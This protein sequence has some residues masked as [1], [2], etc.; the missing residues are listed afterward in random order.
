MG[1][2]RR[3]MLSSIS[4][5]GILSL[6]GCIDSLNL[7]SNR[8]DFN[9][10]EQISVSI[11]DIAPNPESRY[12]LQ[13]TVDIKKQ[14]ADIDGPPVISVSVENIDGPKVILMGT[15]RA[16]FGGETDTENNIALLTRDE[17]NKN[18]MKNNQCWNLEKEIPRSG[19]QYETVLNDGEKSNIDL[20]VIGSSNMDGCIPL[21]KYRFETNY[22]VYLPDKSGNQ[23]VDEFTWGFILETTMVDK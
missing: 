19:T 18:Q 16:V 17:W 9:S 23:L 12:N 13:F 10:E 2:T 22:S 6:S 8:K 21:G 14:T 3:Q 7:N 15:T 20:D 5:G 11:L 1:N 4:L